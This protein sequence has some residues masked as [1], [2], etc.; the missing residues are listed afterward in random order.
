MAELLVPAGNTEALDAALSEGADAVYMGLKCFNAR[1]RSANFAWNQF[2]AAVQ[3][4]HRQK[5]KIFVA[6]NTVIE[7]RETERL[8]RF[9]AY[10]NK[11]GPDG[12]IV[13]DFGV[14]RMCQE[15]FPNMKL[16]ASTQMNVASAAGVNL[17]S[18]EGIKRVVLA[19]ELGFDE[20]K[21]IRA[22]TSAE[23]E[24]FVHGALCVSES[25]LCLFS[26]FLGGK[27]A[28]RGMCTQACRRYYSAEMS[29]GVRSGYFF[30]PLDL[31][32]IDRIPDLVKAGVDSFKIEGRM[33]SA[34]YVGCVT[35]AYRYVLD[36]WQEDRKGAVAAGK[37]ILASDFARQKTR[38]W[39]DSSSAENILNPQQA[40][41]TGIYLGKIE[42]TKTVKN[43]NS[44]ES[45]VY[46]L[47]RGGSYEPDA[48]DSVRLHKKDDSG[49]ESH[50]IRSVMFGSETGI[51]EDKGIRWIDIP[52]EFSAGDSVYLLQTKS[53][54]KRYP[55]SL[56][57]DLSKFRTQ[58]GAQ[59]LPIMDLTPLSKNDLSYFPAGIYI[60]VSTLRDLRTVLSENP[61]RIILELNTETKK[62]LIEEKEVLP[63]SKKNIFISL[64]PYC[65][66][67]EEDELRRTIE[68]LAANG[69]RQWIVNNVSQIAMLRTLDAVSIA[70]PYM[71][72]FN[73]WAVSWLENQNIE[74][75]ITPLE[76]SR[77][78][79]EAEFDNIQRRRVMITLFSYPALF[80]MR[81]QL[82]K[83]YD[84]TYFTDKEGTVFKALSTPDGS[85]VMPEQP[86]SLIDKIGF[87]K[88]AGFSHF[89][90]DLS[91]THVQ[92]SDFRSIMKAMYKGLLLPETSRFNW[93]DGFYSQEKIDKFK[94]AAEHNSE[95]PLR[96]TQRLPNAKK[97][98]AARRNIA[99]KSGRN[100]KAGASRR[101]QP[102]S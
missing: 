87:M 5:K 31:Q 54:T 37:R 42:K 11:I 16:H 102:R 22:G 83:S 15:F 34:E 30:S 66:Q 13:Q 67:S 60:Q 91:K 76:N 61:V 50:K 12:L 92:K 32:L 10:L 53:M 56:P 2:E 71:Y 58:P 88:S 80:R 82:P 1:L 52:P 85:F 62:A 84:F 18:K 96:G 86:F 41:G 72:T 3:A 90:I 17:L 20:I 95:P 94:I 46:A 45:V 49:R 29:G 81:F 57:R 99:G 93:K 38:Y 26:S 100:K 40:G 73:R 36:H 44:E 48:G 70:G 63:V 21:A 19:R 6:V 74:A 4:V 68:C 39:Y 75:F 89:L 35:A 14:V 98:A 77:R 79:I 9:L 27:S 24:V 47:L 43:Y 65:P 23:L 55:H 59:T 78:N 25:G 64:D 28:N 69:F 8:Y 33:K 7:E 97:P 101:R 51:G